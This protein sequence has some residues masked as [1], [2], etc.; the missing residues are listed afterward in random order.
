[1]WCPNHPFSEDLNAGKDVADE[2][3]TGIHCSRFRLMM[4]R[5]SVGMCQFGSGV[6]GASLDVL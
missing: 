5:R 3:F 4:G 2:A 1:M 6:F